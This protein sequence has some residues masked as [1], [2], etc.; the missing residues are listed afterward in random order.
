MDKP[1]TLR[2][3]RAGSRAAD[4]GDARAVS[5]L[6]SFSDLALRDP[7]LPTPTL[8]RSAKDRIGRELRAMYA[9]FERQPIPQR[10]LDLMGKLAEPKD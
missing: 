10:L 9:E 8:D 2:G 3:R 1:T 7:A 5:P 4:P 6:Q